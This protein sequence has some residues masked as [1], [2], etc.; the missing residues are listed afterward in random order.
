ML[1]KFTAVETGDL[2]K[3]IKFASEIIRKIEDGIEL[4]KGIISFNEASLNFSGIINRSNERICE[5]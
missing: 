3:R 5:S 4:L 1:T 2:P